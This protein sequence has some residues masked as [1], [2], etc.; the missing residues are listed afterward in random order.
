MRDHFVTNITSQHQGG[1]L[2]KRAD[3]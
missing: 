3:I 2:M 1:Y